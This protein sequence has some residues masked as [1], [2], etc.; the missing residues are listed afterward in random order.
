MTIKPAIIAAILAIMAPATSIAHDV[1]ANGGPVPAWVKATCCGPEDVHHLLPS[2]IHVTADG[3]MIDG[4]LNGPVPFNRALPSQDG[5]NWA[6]WAVRPDGTQ[7]D[8]YCLFVP[9][10][11]V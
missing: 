3:Y 9:P 10:G 11:A 2:Q 1:W 8:I 6:F 4:Y 5:D 7:T